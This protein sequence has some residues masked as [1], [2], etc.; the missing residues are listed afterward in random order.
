MICPAVNKT[1]GAALSWSAVARELRTR[2]SG[3]DDP[4]VKQLTK[5]QWSV[6]VAA[7]ALVTGR[8]SQDSCGER[9]LPCLPADSAAADT[10]TPR[11][12]D[13]WLFA[14]NPGPV[15]ALLASLRH[16]HFCTI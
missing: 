14:Q 1:A 16:P 15:A 11:P 6:E 3:Q 2:V 13:R 9:G 7:P 5:P 12:S 8:Q 10:L 4:A